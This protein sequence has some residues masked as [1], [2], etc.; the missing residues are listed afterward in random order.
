[1]K[2][3]LLILVCM[4]AFANVKGQEYYYMY[5]GVGWEGAGEMI[6]NLKMWTGSMGMNFQTNNTPRMFLSLSGECIILPNLTGDALKNRANLLANSQNNPWGARLIVDAPCVSRKLI[7]SNLST[8]HDNIELSNT[9]T[10]AFLTANGDDNGFHIKS[11]TAF[12]IHL[13]DQVGIGTIGLQTK[14]VPGAQLT[15]S[16]AVFIGSQNFSG[17]YN[18][19]SKTDKFLLW[20]QKG[21]VSENFALA[22]VADWSDHVFQ[23]NYSLR[24]LSEVKQFIDTNKHLPDVPSEKEVKE[25]G[26]NIH[27]MNKVFMQK[28]EELTLYVIQQQKEIDALKEQ[29]NNK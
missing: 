20:V 17:S 6:G 2:K 5:T 11:N 9:G 27:D 10:D 25:K 21:I 4:M 14:I 8:N 15:V 26:Y 13:H 1:M 29:L 18:I 7:V 24:P 23:P 16:G 3:I 28:I 19:T 12:K 22:K